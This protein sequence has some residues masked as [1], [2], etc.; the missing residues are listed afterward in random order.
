MSDWLDEIAKQKALEQREQEAKWAKRKQEIDNARA[1]QERLNKSVSH[2]VE[3]LFAKLDAQVERA[4]QQNFLLFTRRGNYF[5]EFQIFRLLRKYKDTERLMDADRSVTL[6]PKAEGLEIWFY[7]AEIKLG[8]KKDGTWFDEIQNYGSCSLQCIGTVRYGSLSDSDL[9]NV[10]KWIA[11][12]EQLLPSFRNVI[13]YRKPQYG[14][15]KRGWLGRLF[16]S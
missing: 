6:S 9:S 11:L 12:G 5:K 2:L 16:S 13:P 14:K 1:V 4:K 7:R 10:V 8:W 3:P 15:S